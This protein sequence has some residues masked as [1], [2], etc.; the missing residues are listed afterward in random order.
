[1]GYGWVR[2]STGI[3]DVYSSYI[4]HDWAYESQPGVGIVAGVVPEPSTWALFLCGTIT[5]LGLG[6]RSLGERLKQSFHCRKA[7]VY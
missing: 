3:G 4:L 5:M 6:V 1:M 7:Y 2:L